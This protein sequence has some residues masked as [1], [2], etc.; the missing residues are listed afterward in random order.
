ME[1]MSHIAE[2]NVK[3]I[4]LQ[5]VSQVT[6]QADLRE[7]TPPRAPPKVVVPGPARL[8]CSWR[9]A[10]KIQAA[11]EQADQEQ[12][13]E[14]AGE[15]VGAV[16]AA[17]EIENPAEVALEEAVKAGNENEDVTNDSVNIMKV[18]DDG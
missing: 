5:S 15:E 18:N 10:D 1:D 3:F 2:E 8:R 16:Q 9:R 6:L 12:G 4:Y 14:Q 7:A 17:Q 11:A 13:A